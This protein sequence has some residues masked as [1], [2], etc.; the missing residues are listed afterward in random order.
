M[1]PD[2]SPEP[3]PTVP[4]LQ[5]ETRGPTSQI[6]KPA[7]IEFWNKAFAFRASLVAKLTEAGYGHLCRRIA[8]CHSHEDAL[9][10]KEC[11]TTKIITNRCEHR[12]CPLCSPRLARERVE[13]LKHWAMTIRQPKHVV[14]TA[15]NSATLTRRRVRMFQRAI[16]R[17]RRTTLAQ[18]WR[19]GTW[20]LEVTNESKGWH[21]HAH[22]LVDAR[23]ID[24]VDLSG[25]WAKQI[26]QDFAIVKVKDARSAD[27]LKELLKYV[28]KSSQLCE[29]NGY[30]IAELILAFRGVRSFGVFGS[31]TGLRSQWKQTIRQIRS[32]RSRC[33]CGCNKFV[34]RDARLEELESRHRVRRR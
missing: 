13:E 31:L 30:E 20:S 3:S 6:H 12:W 24:A 14:L 26:G 18:G 9:V 15:R 28:V 7:Q 32:D 27:Y 22:L 17:L 19:S 8:D 10:C 16:A 25:A 2:S 4:D 5:L 11:S 21:L 34:I 1:T 29:W 33:Q 23:W